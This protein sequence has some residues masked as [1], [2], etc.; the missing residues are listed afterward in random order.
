MI[1]ITSIAKFR[2]RV[3]KFSSKY[4]VT[5]A[6]DR[7]KIS[8]N[9]IYEWKHKYDGTWKSLKDK[10]HRPKSH[11][12]QHTQEE[13]D[14]ILRYYHKNKDD[15][16]V[17]WDKIRKKG[18]K[19]AYNSMCRVIRKLGLE[20]ADKRKG[21]K[22]KP[23]QRAE[24]PGQKVQIDVKY[25]PTY[26]V[27]N[28]S[29]YYQYTAIDECT[30]WTFREMYDEHSTYS[31]QDFLAKVIKLCPFPI[32]EIQTD[33]GSEWTNAL[34]STK[35]KP[36]LFEELLEKANIVYHRIRVATPRHNGK[37]ER[38]HRTDEKRFYS[39]MKMFSLDDGRKQLAKY[40]KWSNDIPKICLNF[41]SPNEV[42]EKYLAVM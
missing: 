23:Y 4:G 7:F 29:K 28:G 15:K 17:L 32:R 10:S 24:Y 11:P 21:Y 20:Q 3:I 40:N 16:I 22:P 13:I 9:A 39:K 35:A 33:N 31:S 5:K 12:K 8:R 18:Y 41:Q 19:R 37:V 27:S 30:R 1:S 26:C 6:S 34:K 14:L 38:Q 36:T 25:V 2:Q 42:L